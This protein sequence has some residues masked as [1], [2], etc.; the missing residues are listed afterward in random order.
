MDRDPCALRVPKRS[1]PRGA[2]QGPDARILSS[3][4]LH[5]KGQPHLQTQV[6]AFT[7]TFPELSP[8]VQIGGCPALQVTEHFSQGGGPSTLHEDGL[9]MSQL[10]VGVATG[11]S[12]ALAASDLAGFLD[13]FFSVPPADTGKITH[14]ISKIVTAISLSF[15]F[16]F[17]LL[18]KVGDAF[19]HTTVAN[20]S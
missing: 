8:G 3:Y 17:C 13:F 19:Y 16:T 6:E 11:V 9:L 20:D 1:R 7:Q 10:G 5:L 18:S 14:T 15:I 12:F 2:D 4:N